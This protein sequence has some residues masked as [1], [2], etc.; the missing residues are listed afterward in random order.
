MYIQ[1]YRT[2]SLSH[3]HG[4]MTLYSML[5][6]QLQAPET[7][8]THD[9]V[10]ISVHEL[11]TLVGKRNKKLSITPMPK[12]EVFVILAKGK[13]PN[14]GLPKNFEYKDPLNMW[15]A[16]TFVTRQNPRLLERLEHHWAQ[17]P[18]E[19]GGQAD[20]PAKH[21]V[22][23]RVEGGLFQ[24]LPISTD[25]QQQILRVADGVKPKPLLDIKSRRPDQKSISNHLQYNEQCLKEFCQLIT[26]NHQ[27]PGIRFHQSV[28]FRSFHDKISPDFPVSFRFP[29]IGINNPALA[30]PNNLSAR[31][32]ICAESPRKNRGL[33]TPN[34][35]NF[36]DN[37]A[38]IRFCDNDYRPTALPSEKEVHDMIIELI[39]ASNLNNSE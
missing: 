32:V 39:P 19:P 5:C 29:T 12:T 6:Q 30:K 16:S 9:P 14:I 15:K 28:A 33:T 31:P 21:I 34:L 7:T 2:A 35:V 25:D 38:H 20:L 18:L 1:G 36:F 13:H 17:V 8:E 26:Q 27:E 10:T 24:T 4:G 37:S 3:A 11:K 23:H 22:F